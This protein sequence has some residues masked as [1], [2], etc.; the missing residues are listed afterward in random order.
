M[1]RP[2]PGEVIYVNRKTGR[3]LCRRWNWRNGDFSKLAPGTQNLG[4]NVDGMLSAISRE[5]LERAAEGLKELLLRH[6]GGTISIHYLD[7]GNREMEIT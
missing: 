4:I 6:C 5:E 3:I 7:A 1:E 2:E